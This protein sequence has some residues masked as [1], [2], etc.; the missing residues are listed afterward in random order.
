MELAVGKKDIS[1]PPYVKGRELEVEDFEKKTIT[2]VEDHPDIRYRFTAGQ[3]ISKFL[4]GLKEGKILGVKCNKC[5]R[6]MVPPREFCEVCFKPINEWVEL[7]DTGVVETFS[8]SYIGPDAEPLE[9]PEIV[10]VIA[11]DGASPHMG[12]LHKLGEVKPED[13][14]IGMKVKAVWKPEEEREGA[15]TDIVYWKPLEG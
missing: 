14:Y 3:A 13:V 1:C 11:I 5:G 8:I 15:I 9:E 10:A 4:K 2:Y 6:V 7:K 12:I